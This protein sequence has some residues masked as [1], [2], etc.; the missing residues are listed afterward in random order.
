[1]KEVYICIPKSVAYYTQEVYSCAL[2]RGKSIGKSLSK[3]YNHK[4]HL[5]QTGIARLEAFCD[6]INLLAFG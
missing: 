2:Q 1:M 5:Q 3:L 4:I 6:V